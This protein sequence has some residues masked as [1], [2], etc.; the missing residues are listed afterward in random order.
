MSLNCGHTVCFSC[1]EALYKAHAKKT[2]PFCKAVQTHRRA[3][4]LPKN[5]EILSII[6]EFGRQ[7]SNEGLL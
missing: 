6:N 7:K 1:I 5:Y 3:V 2:C 4:N